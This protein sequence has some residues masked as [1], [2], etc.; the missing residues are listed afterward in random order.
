MSCGQGAPVIGHAQCRLAYP[1][2]A[3][4]LLM[5]SR[6]TCQW[7]FGRVWDG[8]VWFCRLTFLAKILRAMACL[9]FKRRLSNEGHNPRFPSVL[10]IHCEVN[11][12]LQVKYTCATASGLG[13]PAR[14]WDFLVWLESSFVAR[15]RLVW[16]GFAVN[17]SEEEATLQL[18]KRRQP[19]TMLPSLDGPARRA[20]VQGL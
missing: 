11:N 18:E 12:K 13:C 17:Q 6:G 19:R 7:E 8:V 16:F 4:T 5:V 2:T 20:R 3:S 14:K 15:L 1:H 10:P 9:D